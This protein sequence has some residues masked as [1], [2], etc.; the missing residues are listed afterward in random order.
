MYVLDG[1]I[2]RKREK[3]ADDEDDRRWWDRKKWKIFFGARR[4]SLL[5]PFDRKNL[6]LQ[7]LIHPLPP[8]S[9]MLSLSLSSVIIFCLFF[10]F[11]GNSPLERKLFVEA[12]HLHSCVTSAKSIPRGARPPANPSSLSSSWPK[13]FI[14]CRRLLQKSTFYFYFLLFV[15]YLHLTSVVRR[16]HERSETSRWFLIMDPVKWLHIFTLL[17]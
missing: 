3:C 6:W 10:P 7:I 8:F 13:L 12:N 15:L 2:E 16:S 11:G 1:E 17:L 14:V 5:C 4:C 9:P